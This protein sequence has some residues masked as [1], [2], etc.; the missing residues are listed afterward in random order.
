MRTGDSTESYTQTSEL[1]FPPRFLITGRPPKLVPLLELNS[2]D[3][4]NNVILYVP[5]GLLLGFLLGSGSGERRW[6]VAFAALLFVAAVSASLEVL[7]FFSRSGG[8][9]STT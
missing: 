8:R 7:Q 2:K 9:R 5:L 4:I 3:A 6:R 1:E